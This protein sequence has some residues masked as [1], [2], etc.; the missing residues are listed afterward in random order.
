MSPI[1][2]QTTLL[3]VSNTKAFELFTK[4]QHLEA[5]L[6]RKANVVPEIG[7]AYELFWRPDDPEHDSTMGCRILAMQSP[8]FINFEWKGPERFRHFMNESQPL[9]NVTVTFHQKVDKTE[10][11]LIHTGWRDYG[12][13][14]QAVSYFNAA[15]KSAF[16]KLEVYSKMHS[17]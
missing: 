7:E 17:S 16:E 14:H 8:Y 13:W 4:N 12:E 10:V 9:T 6:C 15:W 1:I 2:V 5:W 11:S 3:E